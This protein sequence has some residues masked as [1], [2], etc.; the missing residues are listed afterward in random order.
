MA[1][2]AQRLYLQPVREE[3]IIYAAANVDEILVLAGFCADPRVRVRQVT[4]GQFIGIAI[5]F[6]AC[7]ADA[8]R[9]ERRW[10]SG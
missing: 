10:T 9:E 1:D 7:A 3:A 8:T 4:T 2:R 6:G 5:P